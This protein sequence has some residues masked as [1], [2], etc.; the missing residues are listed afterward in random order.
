MPDCQ[1]PG[2]GWILGLDPRQQGAW[3][4]LRK[5]QMTHQE[6]KNIFSRSDADFGQDAQRLLGPFALAD[7]ENSPNQ[8]DGGPLTIGEDRLIENHFPQQPLGVLDLCVVLQ[9]SSL[10]E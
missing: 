4:I 2:V 10:L 3:H 7:V 1:G 9:D 6:R 8:P 5:S